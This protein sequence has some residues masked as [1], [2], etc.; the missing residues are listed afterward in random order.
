M[1]LGIIFPGQGSQHVGMAADFVNHPSTQHLFTEANAIL[2]FDITTL[3]LKGDEAELRQTEN[4]QPALLLAG[5]AAWTYLKSTTPDLNVAAF[6]GH[7]LGEYTALVAAEVIS[8]KDGLMLV[9][10]R[11][12]LMASAMPSG[13]GGMSA[14]LG[15]DI[16]TTQTLAEKHGVYVAN[17]NADGQIILSGEATKLAAS[18]EDFK[19]A[20]AKRV[21]PLP[22]AGAFHTPYMQAAADAMQDVLTSIS[23]H[24]PTAP[25][26]L[27]TTA[28]VTRNPKDIKDNLPAQIVSPVRWRE[29]MAALA[30]MG[31]TDLTELG[32]GKVLTNLAKRSSH[33]FTA[34]ALTAPTEV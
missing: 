30:E 6:A 3:M 25:V 32:A 33:G 17:D 9:R 34:D 13:Q 22:V 27:N 21:L 16:K 2:S 10:K 28:A 19:N 1:T 23:F 26:I 12:E 31:I 4:T 29:T 14:V 5:V 7:S 8:F 11:G 18:S 15:L 24:E 20:G